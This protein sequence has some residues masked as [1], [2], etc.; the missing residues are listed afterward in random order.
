[1]RAILYP[2]VMMFMLMCGQVHASAQPGESPDVIL[3]QVTQEL[4]S[5][6]RQNDKAVHSQPQMIYDIVN[7]ILVPYID[8]HTMSKWVIGRQA[9][10]S[11]SDKQKDEFAREFK[12][13]LV[14]TYASTLK[15]YNNQAIEYMPIRGGIAGKSRVQVESFIK[16][17][18]KESIKVTYRMVNSEGTWKVYDI[19]IEG[20]SLLKGFQSQFAEEIRQQGGLDKLIKRLHQH[21]E[22]PLT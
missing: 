13:L 6:L 20:V 19:S 11:A 12:D 9:W 2:F 14:R 5:T 3:K 10:T 17:A 21:N 8:W 22:K 4:I 18:G 1:M 15:A 7:R 16:E